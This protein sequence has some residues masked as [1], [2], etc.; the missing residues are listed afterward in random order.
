MKAGCLTGFSNKKSLIAQVCKS[1]KQEVRLLNRGE[2]TAVHVVTVV[3]YKPIDV[4]MC[5]HPIYIQMYLDTYLVTDFIAGF[6]HPQ[7]F[8]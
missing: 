5:T 2:T 8:G 3:G 4:H 1:V 6:F 7:G